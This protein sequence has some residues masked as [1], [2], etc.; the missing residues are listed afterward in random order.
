MSGIV[1]KLSETRGEVNLAGPNSGAHI[2]EI[3]SDLGYTEEQI[4]SWVE[5]G[6]IKTAATVEKT[7]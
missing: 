3:L 1:T 6:I 5:K 2:E 7:L 4:E